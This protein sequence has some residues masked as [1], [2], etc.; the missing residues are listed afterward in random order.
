[1]KCEIIRNDTVIYG[2]LEYQPDQVSQVLAK[3]G[4]VDFKPP[5]RLSRRIDIATVSIYPVT[6]Q[7]PSLAAGE[8]YGASTRTLRDN[9][10]LYV[11]AVMQKSLSEIQ[12]RLKQDIAQVHDAYDKGRIE[13]NGV[14][15]AIDVEAR[16]NAAGTVDAFES[17]NISP[18]TWSGK[19]KDTEG[20]FREKATIVVNNLTEA[21]ALKSAIIVAVAKGFAVRGAVESEIDAGDINTLKTYSAS[22]RF[23]ALLAA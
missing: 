16:T 21:Q 15:I 7:R 11:Y 4:I 6:E 8:R 19:L 2:P 18:I 9:D 22:A 10:V 12:A 13:Y 23:N 1:M 5:K 14:W 20:N 3:H 17:G